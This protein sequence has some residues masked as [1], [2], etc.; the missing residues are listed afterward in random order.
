MHPPADPHL[1]PNEH[2]DQ[3]QPLLQINE[4]SRARRAPG[5]SRTNRCRGR[6][7]RRGR[8]RSP[9][10]CGR[11]RH[12]Q[13][14]WRRR[15]RRSRSPPCGQKRSRSGDPT[16]QLIVITT[17]SEKGGHHAGTIVFICGATSIGEIRPA[18]ER[19]PPDERSGQAPQSKSA[20]SGITGVPSIIFR[21][22]GTYRDGASIA[23]AFVTERSTSWNTLHSR[24]CV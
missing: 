21:R 18:Y 17:V 19:P 24:S 13:A 20:S 16:R 12:Q 9:R 8:S 23:S 3:R 10:A 6:A 4:A 1:D 11:S 22:A 7:R 15:A 2:Q 14:C 5:M